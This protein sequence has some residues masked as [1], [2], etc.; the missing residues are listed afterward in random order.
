MIH[1]VSKS[2]STS[3]TLST[4]YTCSTLW[5]RTCSITRYSHTSG[6]LLRFINLA[7]PGAGNSLLFHEQLPYPLSACSF[8]HVVRFP[9]IQVSTQSKHIHPIILLSNRLKSRTVVFLRNSVAPDASCNFAHFIDCSFTGCL[10]PT[11]QLD[12][13]MVCRLSGLW[14]PWVVLLEQFC[15]TSHST[16]GDATNSWIYH[17]LLRNPH[18]TREDPWSRCITDR[19]EVITSW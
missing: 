18:R 1:R 17:K 4:L 19:G 14:L 11:L 13:C 8:L 9:F 10:L 7:P 16:A 12:Y 2:A 3:F 5:A 15:L 6:M